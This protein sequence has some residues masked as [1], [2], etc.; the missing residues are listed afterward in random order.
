MVLDCVIEAMI[1]MVMDQRPLR[2][3][4]RPFN[5]M[6]LLD[7]LR[8]GPMRLDQTNNTIQVATC[9]PEALDDLWMAVVDMFVR[10]N[11]HPTR[12]MQIPK[13]ILGIAMVA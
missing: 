8:T 11:E 12:G 5:R 6:E 13:V 3:I 7:D 4:D 2:C 9:S 1:K 10:H